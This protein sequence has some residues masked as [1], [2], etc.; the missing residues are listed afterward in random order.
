LTLLVAIPQFCVPPIQEPEVLLLI[1]RLPHVVARRGILAHQI[2]IDSAL[3]CVG[4]N[5]ATNLG[6]ATP[7]HLCVMT[8]IRE[9]FRCHYAAV[10]ILLFVDPQHDRSP[11]RIPRPLG[12]HSKVLSVAIPLLRGRVCKCI[13]RRDMGGPSLGAGGDR[14]APYERRNTAPAETCNGSALAVM[15]LQDGV[16]EISIVTS[17]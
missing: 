15:D 9:I 14:V 4:R 10:P 13:A 5:T 6:R 2:V 3:V 17:L 12:G 7:D 11:H 1:R 16:D 8:D